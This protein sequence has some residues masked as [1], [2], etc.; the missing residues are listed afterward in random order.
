MQKA[1]DLEGDE[2]RGRVQRQQPR[3]AEES[4]GRQQPRPAEESV[5]T[6]TPS[7]KNTGLEST[8]IME[9]KL[10]MIVN[11]IKQYQDRRAQRKP[12]LVGI[13]FTDQ[14]SKFNNT[15]YQKLLTQTSKTNKQRC[16]CCHI[17]DSVR[18]KKGNRVAVYVCECKEEG[19]EA[20]K[21][22]CNKI[23]YCPSCWNTMHYKESFERK[24]DDVEKCLGRQSYS[25]STRTKAS[26]C[27]ASSIGSS[28]KELQF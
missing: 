5:G 8:K 9:P 6:T 3:P 15:H 1:K 17:F 14:V 20:L 16:Q 28:R 13:H 26:S 21:G 4:V 7:T 2:Q 24:I 12:R 11:H 22:A 25:K 23:M 19:V 10:Q 18:G 27:N